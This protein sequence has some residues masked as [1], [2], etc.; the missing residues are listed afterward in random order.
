MS[1][2]APLGMDYQGGNDAGGFS[3]NRSYNQISS[4]GGGNRGGNRKSY[5]EQ[6]LIPVTAKMLL[7]TVPN[8]EGTLALADGRELYQVTIVGA[9]RSA[10][11]NSTNVTY[12]LEDG[13]GLIEIKQ[14][15]TDNDC[16]ALAEMRSRCTQE[17]VYIKCIGQIK[18]YDGK[19]TLVADQVRIVNS[20]DEVTHHFLE[21]V[22]SGEKFKRAGSFVGASTVTSMHSSAGVGFGA[23]SMPQGFGGSGTGGTGDALKDQVLNYIKE[24]GGE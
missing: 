21:V 6:T 7:S 3:T 8:G 23:G 14:W 16:R 15:N 5:D 2:L 10:A 22:Y 13:T 4:Q 9:V 12:E 24:Y 18:D 11:D 19:K 1:C 17:H 20:I